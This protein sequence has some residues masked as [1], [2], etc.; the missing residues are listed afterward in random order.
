MEKINVALV[1]LLIMGIDIGAG[2]LGILAQIEEKKVHSTGWI[3]EC[4][5]LDH[6]ALM[7]G[8]GAAALLA[9]SHVISHLSD[10]YICTCSKKG[11]K[12]ETSSNKQLTMVFLFLSWISF[13][14]GFS[15]LL[16]GTLANLKL[17]RQ[18]IFADHHFLSEGVSFCFLHGFLAAIYYKLAADATIQEQGIS[19]T[20]SV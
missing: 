1:C 4:R 9:F 20:T 6:R 14:F 5:H 13:G 15:L 16:V 19:P 17:R 3:P 10:G 12:N 11:H 8:F 2:L 7:L 18:C